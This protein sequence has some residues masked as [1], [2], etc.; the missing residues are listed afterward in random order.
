MDRFEFENKLRGMVLPG[1]DTEGKAIPLIDAVGAMMPHKLFRYRAFNERSIDAFEKD[2]IYTVPATW[3]NDPYDTLIKYN[4]DN[5]KE[6]MESIASPKGRKQLQALYSQNK[7]FLDLIWDEIPE[8]YRIDIKERL[9]ETKDIQ[10]EQKG[11]ENNKQR[12][13]SSM[14]E[15]FPSLSVYMKSF[16]TI[17]CLSE[18]VTSVLMWSHYADSHKGFALEYDFRPM[19]ET[20]V[21]DSWLFPVIYSNKRFD[22]SALLAEFFLSLMDVETICADTLA[23]LKVA[24]F[25][26]KLWGYE[27]EWRFFRLNKDQAPSTIEYRPTAI[28]Y[29][30]NMEWE[31]KERLHAIALA[32]GIKEQEM[33]IKYDSDDYKMMYRKLG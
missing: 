27:K 11:K 32:K 2:L 33:T 4:L 3:F 26:S 5:I 30:L 9:A 18:D 12:V 16:T 29:G 17:A 8:K 10:K 21:P 20:P 7:P 31:N 1:A 14:S 23:V 24:L 19:L 22:A 25:K 28:Y 15:A 13:F 6:N